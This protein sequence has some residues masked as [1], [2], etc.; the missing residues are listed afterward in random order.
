[1]ATHKPALTHKA[2]M[3]AKHP[4]GGRKGPLLIPCGQVPG[5]ALQVTPGGSRSWLMRYSFAGMARVIGFGPAPAI[6]LAD[7]RQAATASR[8][9]LATGI[10]PLQAR[11]DAVK[12]AATAKAAAAANTFRAVA[13]DFI[14]AHEAAWRNPPRCARCATMP[15][16][17]WA[18]YQPSWRRW[19][20]YALAAACLP[21]RWPSPS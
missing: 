19:T 1:M 14:A 3:A 12:A 4:G 9:L 2:V 15:L 7:A 16:C 17:P 10:D 13:A 18:A 5:L 20:G 11:D 21:V 6:S 8:A